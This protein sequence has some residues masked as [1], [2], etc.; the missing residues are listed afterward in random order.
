MF[1]ARIFAFE[2]P[3]H[4]P[5]D[6]RKRFVTERAKHIASR[7]KAVT[8]RQIASENSITLAFSARDDYDARQPISP[9]HPKNCLS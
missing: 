6:S 2:R 8:N 3:Y 5:S 1:N 4:R 9:S 7:A